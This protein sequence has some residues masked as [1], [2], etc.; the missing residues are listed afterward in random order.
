M[1]TNGDSAAVV[2]DGD[3]VVVVDHDADLPAEARQGLIHGVV[4][5][6]VDKV[7]K[8]I[9][10]GGPDVHRGALPDWIE[11]LQDLDGTCIVTH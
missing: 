10:T 1:H 8:A 7:V 4:D 11:T 6:F 5:D 2:S 9:R 3:A